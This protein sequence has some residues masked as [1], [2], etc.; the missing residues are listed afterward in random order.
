MLRNDRCPT[1]KI[2]R[3]R[4]VALPATLLLLLFGCGEGESR[5]SAVQI[6]RTG[7]RAEK[8]YVSVEWT[9]GVSTPPACRV[10]EDRNG[11]VS[12]YFEPDARVS[13]HGNTFS[14]EFVPREEAQ[15][16]HPLEKG[17]Y[18]V[19]CTVSMD[20]GKSGEDLVKVESVP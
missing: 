3:L 1:G 20:S 5:S 17:D 9:R 15:T 16:V 14:K 2:R 19:R 12:D 11:P 18:Y 10:L 8:I 4:N 6:E 13:L 7:W